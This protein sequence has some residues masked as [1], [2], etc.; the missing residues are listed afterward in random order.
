MNAVDP[1]FGNPLCVAAQSRNDS[2]AMFL[3]SCQGIDPTIHDVSLK[4][5]LIYAACKARLTIVQKI[6]EF[7]GDR[8]NERVAELNRAIRTALESWQ[9]D[10]PELDRRC[11]TNDVSV[12]NPLKKWR[13][14]RVPVLL[15]LLSIPCVDVNTDVKG[16]RLIICAAR[17]GSSELVEKLLSFSEA[18]VNDYH[19]RGTALHVAL[20]NS[21]TEVSSMLIDCDRVDVNAIG[22]DRTTTL[23]SAVRGGDASVLRALIECPRFDGRRQNVSAALGSAIWISDG[24]LAAILLRSTSIQIDMGSPMPHD[25]RFWGENRSFLE[26][27]FRHEN[28]ELHDAILD[29]P[30][31]M[32]AA[33]EPLLRCLEMTYRQDNVRAV[34][35]I[36]RC[37]GNQVNILAKGGSLLAVAMRSGAGNM[38]TFI[39]SHS[40]FDPIQ[41]KFMAVLKAAIESGQAD[42]IKLA[43]QLPG[44]DINGQFDNGFTPLTFSVQFGD[45]NALRALLGVPGLNLNLNDREGRT[46]ITEVLKKNYHIPAELTERED[47]DWNIRERSTLDTPLILL[48]KSPYS[49][50]SIEWLLGRAAS[51]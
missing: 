44:V 14:K 36:L 43:V 10:K 3:L 37:L 45:L 13:D 30:S 8:I 41:T 2:I 4:T 26:E 40:S 15:Y 48:A 42:C 39:T 21:F 1:E 9:S 46:L 22:L 32:N 31:F 5:L 24:Q 23:E 17:M 11:D 25:Q 34:Q 6:A 35:R 18:K 38:A 29:H 49:D 33:P 20:E 7:H 27:A 16:E 47:V 28:T 12:R 50:R 51:T 19:H